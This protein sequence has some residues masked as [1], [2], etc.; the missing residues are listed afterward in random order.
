MSA[1][2]IAPSG[3]SASNLVLNDSFSGTSLSATWNTS[4]TR[5]GTQSGQWDRNENS[6]S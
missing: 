3:N 1:N 5:N 6:G 2:P 4:M